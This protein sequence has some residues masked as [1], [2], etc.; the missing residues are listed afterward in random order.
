M[1]FNYLGIILT[2][3]KAIKVI[4]TTL[5]PY[6]QLLNSTKKQ[7]PQTL[8]PQQISP[9]S[10]SKEAISFSSSQ[11]EGNT[12]KHFITQS[13]LTAVACLLSYN[14]MAEETHS[15]SQPPYNAN[16][17][18]ISAITPG[19]IVDTNFAT[20]NIRT[21]QRIILA[22]DP[23]SPSGV[24]LQQVQTDQNGH[25]IVPPINQVEPTQLPA[26]T[27]ITQNP[28][29]TPQQTDPLPIRTFDENISTEAIDLQGV[30]SSTFEQIPATTQGAKVAINP[31]HGG[32]N[33]ACSNDGIC[34]DEFSL[35]IANLI[36]D[37]L[38]SKGV[39]I[40]LTR[41]RDV[42]ESLGELTNDI[43]NANADAGLLIHFNSAENCTG[44][45]HGPETFHGNV[46][47]SVEL[48]QDL[49][50]G[51]LD[52]YHEMGDTSEQGRG[53]KDADGTRAGYINNIDNVPNALIEVGFGCYPKDSKLL[54]DP[55]FHN[56]LAEKLSIAL[57][58]N[59]QKRGK[60]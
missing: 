39:I 31:G 35:I 52:A 10:F 9:K 25:F 24:S 48:S 16:A 56:V 38:E 13:A 57:I 37:K 5:N 26:Q 20:K 14:L 4:N 22:Y 60:Y 50:D 40:S 49:Q 30:N 55:Q 2:R 8:I 36:K 15:I 29:T 41:D 27:Q 43:M 32:G 23:T 1:F 6:G 33:G 19:N 7:H 3:R 11:K 47:G 42:G 54:N 17:P 44:T 51:M 21:A 53:I 45:A 12:L 28:F 46:E 34:E 18:Q 58:N 59:L